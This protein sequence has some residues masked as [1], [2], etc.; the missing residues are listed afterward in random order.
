MAL[1]LF[2]AHASTCSQKVRLC[3]AEK[4]V[5]DWVSRPIDILTGENLSRDYLA[6]N[7]N[8]VVPAF[9]HDGNPI[10]ES[11]V[12]CEYLD[13][14]FPSHPRLV[15]ESAVTRATMRAW[16]RYIDEV[17]S[18]AIRVPS[19]QKLFLPRFKAMTDAEFLAFVT[20]AITP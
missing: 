14:V 7:P 20:A 9:L 17:P 3:L 10:I 13:E 2:H 5:R 1:E 18:M 16:L 12:M 6:V 4:Q 19:F 8:G 11:T 15:P